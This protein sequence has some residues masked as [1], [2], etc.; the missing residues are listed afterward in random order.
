MRKTSQF[1]KLRDFGALGQKQT[2]GFGDGPQ[3]HGGEGVYAH[4]ETYWQSAQHQAAG[5]PQ[6]GQAPVRA[7]DHRT[8]DGGGQEG[9]KKV[10]QHRRRV[11]QQGAQRVQIQNAD[12]YIAHQNADG[13]AQNVDVGVAGEDIHGNEVQHAA[14]Q[15]IHHRPS[16]VAVGLHNGGRY[17]DC[18]V[19][20]DGNGENEHEPGCQIQIGARIAAQQRGDGPGQHSQAEGAG[21][22]DEARDAHGGFLGILG[23]RVVAQGQLGGDGG[24]DADGDGGDEGAG[25]IEDGQAHTIDA[26]HGVGGGLG[27]AQIQQ[28]AHVDFRLHHGKELQNGGAYR[29][30]HG[31]HHQALG[32]VSVGARRLGGHRQENVALAEAEEQI[33]GGHQTAGGDAQNRAAGGQRHAA[34]GFQQEQGGKHSHDQLY[35]RLDDLRNGGG[36]HV[37]LA[38]EEAP[39]GAHDADEQH[40]RAETADGGPGIRLVLELSKLPAEYRHQKRAGNA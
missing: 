20:G 1:Q 32:G 12:G 23:F 11:A 8:H 9:A 4:A 28:L 35:H 10:F 36:D 25:H 18:G 24:D 37:A 7:I 34:G 5:Q 30:G 26:P 27:V 13:G 6:S 38:L 29:D 22:G 2:V 17:H 21:H 16:G 15:H 33:D 39:E 3:L 19:K 40:T 31:D 14:H